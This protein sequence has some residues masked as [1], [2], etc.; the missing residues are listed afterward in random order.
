MVIMQTKA[1]SVKSRTIWL[2]LTPAFFVVPV[3]T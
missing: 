1:I 3:V 2:V